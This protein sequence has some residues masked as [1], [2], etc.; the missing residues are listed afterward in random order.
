MPFHLQ[1]KKR[2]AASLARSR[3]RR[4]NRSTVPLTADLGAC[5]PCQWKEG[6]DGK[7]GNRSECEE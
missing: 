1:L 6:K 7:G 5:M 3:K 2:A 4:G